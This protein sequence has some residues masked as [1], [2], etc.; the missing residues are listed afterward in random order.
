[1]FPG[2]ETPFDLPWTM[3]FVAR[4]R[5]QVENLMELP[6]E[7]R[8]PDTILWWGS[9]EELEDWLDRVMGVKE[10]EQDISFV[11]QEGDIG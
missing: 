9:P 8:P 7:K 4:K 2:F 3:S 11:I 1:M 5:Q 6:K 10:P